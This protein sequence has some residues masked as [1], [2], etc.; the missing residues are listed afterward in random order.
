M[1]AVIH[2]GSTSSKKPCLTSSHSSLH[3]PGGGSVL[4][5]GPLCHASQSCYLPLRSGLY[6]IPLCITGLSSAYSRHSINAHQRMTVCLQAPHMLPHLTSL[7]G[8][9][10]LFFYPWLN[11]ALEAA[12][13]NRLPAGDLALGKGQQRALGAAG[14]GSSVASS[15]PPTCPTR[16]AG[17]GPRMLCLH[18]QSHAR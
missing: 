13:A 7:F 4:S 10:G 1:H 9:L 18:S 8:S 14:K 2:A 15:S 16:D 6:L 17:S 12:P 11:E 3:T 5:H